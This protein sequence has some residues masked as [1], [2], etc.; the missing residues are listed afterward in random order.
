MAE[1]KD[2]RIAVS[3]LYDYAYEELPSLRVPLPK[4]GAPAWVEE[5]RLY[6][7]KGPIFKS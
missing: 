2:I 1:L 4:Q 3:G 5:K 7:I 6:E